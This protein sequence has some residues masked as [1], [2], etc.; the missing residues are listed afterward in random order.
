MVSS[1]PSSTVTSAGTPAP[2]SFDLA[3]WERFKKLAFDRKYLIL[4][5][6]G[7]PIPPMDLVSIKRLFHFQLTLLD[8][9]LN[10]ELPATNNP[11]RTYHCLMTQ[12]DAC[13]D[14][15]RALLAK[16]FGEETS[17][18]R[19]LNSFKTKVL[20]NELLLSDWSIQG[21]GTR[22]LFLHKF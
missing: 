9:P 19:I 15:L 21:D 6:P 13:A 17:H 12:S 7:S 4:D 16:T 14:E 10:K 2:V 11:T 22:T 8:G 3:R 18:L 1:T 5:I 20:S